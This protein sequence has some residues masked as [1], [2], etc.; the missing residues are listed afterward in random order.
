MRHQNAENS[1]HLQEDLWVV[2]LMLLEND[3]KNMAQ[4]YL[5]ADLP[6]WLAN[7]IEDKCQ[8]PREHPLSWVNDNEGTSLI[9]WLLWM[10]STEASVKN[11]DTRVRNKMLTRLEPFLVQGHR[12]CRFPSPAILYTMVEKLGLLHHL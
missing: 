6:I 12:V 8:V 1:A 3:G 2:Y 4:L 11:E 5:W 10:S 7:I 9:L